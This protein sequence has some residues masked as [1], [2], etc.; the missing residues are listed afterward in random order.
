MLSG[1]SYQVKRNINP[2]GGGRFKG[3]PELKVAQRLLVKAKHL[4][5]F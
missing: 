5:L 4:A 2:A 3:N 1:Y